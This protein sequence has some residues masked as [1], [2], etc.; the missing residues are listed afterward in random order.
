MRTKRTP[1]CAVA[2]AKP[3]A[4]STAADREEQRLAAQT[5]ALDRAVEPLDDAWVLLAGFAARDH[6]RR[7]NPLEQARVPPREAAEALGQ[8][9]IR[10]Q[11]TA[12]ERR[13]HPVRPRP[14][15]L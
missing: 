1:R 13:Q 8:R 10:A 15:A 12:V 5:M 11:Q 14:G 4:S 3:T 6:D 9:G 7:G 2:A